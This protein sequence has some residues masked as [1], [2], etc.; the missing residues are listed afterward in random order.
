VGLFYIYGHTNKSSKSP[1]IFKLDHFPR[2]N[3][4][5][6][7]SKA[8]SI[9]AGG[10]CSVH[11]FETIFPPNT[12]KAIGTASTERSFLIRLGDFP[13]TACGANLIAFNGRSLAATGP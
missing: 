11:I 10:F 8:A 5:M 4:K 3:I 6:T 13:R 12:F 9:D 1:W 7:E 2:Q